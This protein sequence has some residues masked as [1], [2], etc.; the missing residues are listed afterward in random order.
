[1]SAKIPALIFVLAL[2]VF[3]GGLINSQTIYVYN[4]TTRCISFETS[5]ESV[6]LSASNSAMLFAPA[7]DDAGRGVA[8]EINVKTLPGDGSVLVNIDNIFFWEDTQN[9]IRTATQVAR[10]IIGLNTSAVNLVYSVRANASV[11]EGPSAGAAL[12]VV[13]VAALRGKSP[14]TSIM[15]TGTI[16]PDGTIGQVGE[17]LA[18]ARAAKE[19]GALMFLVPRGQSSEI[20]YESKRTCEKIGM[21]EICKPVSVPYS[22]DIETEVGIPIVEVLRLQEA[23]DYFI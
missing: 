12:A 14:N 3:I 16:N 7:V 9:S 4:E 15:I 8:T 13:T 17:V 20:K 6:N 19:I 18:K 1:M 10:N 11:I 22:V 21:T 23:L 5:Y 2:G